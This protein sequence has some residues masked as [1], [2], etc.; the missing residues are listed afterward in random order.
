MAGTSCMALAPVPIT[1]TRLPSRSI[2]SPGQRAVW[3]DGPAK[4]SDPGRSGIFGLLKAPTALM[5]TAAVCTVVSPSGRPGHHLPVLI[6]LVP[7]GRHHLGAE[8]DAVRDVEVGRHLRDVGVELVPQREV[9]RPVGSSEGEGVEVAR[10]VDPTPGVVVLQPGA[11]HGVVALEDRVRDAGGGQADPRTYSGDAGPDDEDLE[12]GRRVEGL[13]RSLE[14]AQL[15]G[16][17]RGVGLGHVLA[18]AGLHHLDEQRGGWGVD[19]HG[20]ALVPGH[21]RLVGRGAD[22]VLDVVG[23]PTGVVVVE[24][25]G[26]RGTVGLVQP[27]PVAGQVDQDHEQG[28]DVGYVDRL[29]PPRPVVHPLKP[30]CPLNDYYTQSYG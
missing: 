21:D 5:T 25:P 2:P 15:V 16:D 28:G 12:A 4:E 23:Q 1:A 22:L 6:A 30:P 13:G 3:A 10:R 26:P 19:G 18:D 20:L 27:A 8:H 9:L 11:A 7:G 29:L 24:A 17:D 14:Q